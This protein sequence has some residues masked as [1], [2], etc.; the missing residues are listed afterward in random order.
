MLNAL[1]EGGMKFRSIFFGAIFAV[2]VSLMVGCEMKDLIIKEMEIAEQGAY[3]QKN[4]TFREADAAT[5]LVAQKYFPIGMKKEKALLL[6]NQLYEDGFEVLELK[7]G[8]T[9]NWPNK[10][11]RSYSNVNL[12]KK[13]PHG[14]IG[15]VIE[16]Q[17]DTI[18]LI[19][20]RTAVI[21][22]KFDSNDIIVESEG[23]INTSGI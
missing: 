2:Y 4:A 15:Y 1:L 21:S 20:T 11:F 18:N 16:K 5:S 22:I 23:R 19:I 3:K 10:E 9:R 8:G 14:T 7:N 13:Y 12:E 6:I 17:Y